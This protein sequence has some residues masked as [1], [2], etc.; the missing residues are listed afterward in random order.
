[1]N[2]RIKHYLARRRWWLKQKL[3]TP[4]RFYGDGG[5][6]HATTALDV[7]VHN[8]KVVAVWFRCQPLAFKATQ[9]NASRAAEM[10]SMYTE[11]PMSAIA[12]IELV[13]KQ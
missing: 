7:E 5:T 12:G 1:M 11:D 4:G 10:R 8:G 13:D 3:A 9:V 2:D 6:I